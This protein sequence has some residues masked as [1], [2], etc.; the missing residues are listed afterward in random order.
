MNLTSA[1]MSGHLESFC[2][3]TLSCVSRD[4]HNLQHQLSDIDGDHFV[5]GVAKGSP[6]FRLEGAKMREHTSDVETWSYAP[7]AA[8][9]LATTTLLE[10][11]Y[12]TD[13]T[14]GSLHLENYFT[15]VFSKASA[16]RTVCADD[17]QSFENTT[18]QVLLPML[19]EHEAWAQDNG[20]PGPFR[21]IQLEKP[22][23]ALSGEAYTNDSQLTMIWI[24]PSQEMH[25]VTAGLVILEPISLG[26]VNS[27]WTRVGVVCSV[28]ARWNSY[29]LEIPDSP[30]PSRFS[31]PFATNIS[32]QNCDDG[33]KR[34]VLRDIDSKSQH[35]SAETQWLERLIQM[36]SI[37]CTKI[38]VNWSSPHTSLSN[39]FCAGDIPLNILNL[40]SSL[41]TLLIET[42]ETRTSTIIAE[43]ISRIGLK[44]Q[45]IPSTKDGGIEDTHE[46]ETAISSFAC[47][48]A[49]N[50]RVCFPL[51]YQRYITGEYGV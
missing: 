20:T 51:H 39:V 7:H 31:D 36:A 21:E 6:Y 2:P 25:S 19:S 14:R 44:P 12:L 17:L 34:E 1:H 8:T 47:P 32:A 43:A 23:W 41:K 10:D 22:L 38:L 50:R 16:V 29:V 5:E 11:A 3:D 40:T 37:D 13:S 4:P 45:F 35:I 48:E 24:K 33:W 49:A 15:N 46:L 18:A 9:M 28:D 26:D 42:I 27:S 30:S